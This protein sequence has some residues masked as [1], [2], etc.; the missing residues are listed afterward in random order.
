[1][2]VILTKVSQT[3]SYE[4]DKLNIPQLANYGCGMYSLYLPVKAS[5][6]ARLRLI[7][8]YMRRGFK[9]TGLSK[10]RLAYANF[11]KETSL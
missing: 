4:V 5:K 9:L 1:M 2:S 3:T 11:I 8:E 7:R 10:F 6:T